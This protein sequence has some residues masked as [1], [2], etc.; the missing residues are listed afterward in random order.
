MVKGNFYCFREGEEGSIQVPLGKFF[1]RVKRERK[2]SW[3]DL[4]IKTMIF[5]KNGKKFFVA[6]F[7]KMLGRVGRMLAEG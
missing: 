5:N 4:Q 1:L 7:R 2:K 6:K 3:I